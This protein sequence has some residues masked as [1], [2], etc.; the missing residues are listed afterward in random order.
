M[1]KLL[2]GVLILAVLA[3]LT[4]AAAPPAMRLVRMWRGPKRR[5]ETLET[6]EVRRGDLRITVLA[7]GIIGSA[8]QTILECKLEKLEVRTMGRGISAGG[9]SSIIDVV[10]EGTEVK[11]GDVICRL[12]SS[13]Y[14]EL[15]RQQEL[16]VARVRS[17]HL[18]AELNLDLSKRA[19]EEFKEGLMK[20][21]LR[22][23]DLQI[24]L[25]RSELQR[26]DDRVAWDRRMLDKGYVS[27]AQ[28][29]SDESTLRRSRFQLSQAVKAASVYREFTLY[30]LTRSLEND[31]RGAE[32]ALSYQDKRLERVE[33]RL[34]LLNEQVVECTI[35]A[36]HDGMVV[37]ANDPRKQLVIEPGLAVFQH[38]KLFY[39]PDL[40]QMQVEALLNESVVSNIA[41]GMHS[42]IVVE[43][44]PSQT[45]EG[46]VDRVARLPTLDFRNDSK[47]YMGMVRFDNVSSRLRP[48]MTAEVEITTETRENVLTVPSTA[49]T[50]EDGESVCYVA[51]NEELVRRRVRLGKSTR[52]QLEVTSGL[53]EGEQVVLDPAPVVESGD[54]LVRDETAGQP[55]SATAFAASS[56]PDST[57][58]RNDDIISSR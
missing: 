41:Q 58:K 49:I 5:V 31:I 24:T 28:V 33:G 6:P 42:R 2:R 53:S 26:N 1:S 8:K 27:K 57:S 36:P 22:D 17:D 25:A 11:K 45:F 51:D 14:E 38:Q 7:G 46:H 43:G 54:V 44:V 20:Q 18:V 29:A 37:Y 55:A 39:L 52:D 19:L 40:Q 16:N 48:G 12:D 9:A 21:T 23:Y 50:V 56:V 3:G 13:D 15:V 34:K 30:K 10:P 35:R 32:S 4:A 47:N